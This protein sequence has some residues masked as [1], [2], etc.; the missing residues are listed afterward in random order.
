MYFT[1][2]SVECSC[3]ILCIGF[4]QMINFNLVKNIWS[5][6][7]NKSKP[8]RPA[9]HV[10]VMSAIGTGLAISR[11]SCISLKP[12]ITHLFFEH[13]WW[14][15]AFW[16]TTFSNELF[17]IYF[18]SIIV[19]LFFV[20]YFHSLAQIKI[21]M[22]KSNQGGQWSICWHFSGL[23]SKCTPVVHFGLK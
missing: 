3:F 17:R 20:F 19:Y 11:M 10:G 7:W 15:G 1:H 13:Y 21:L 4:M 6:T 23:W 14:F 16:N 9:L 5:T 22:N 2:I 8:F 12:S 18:C